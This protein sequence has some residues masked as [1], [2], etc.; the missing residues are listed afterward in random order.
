MEDEALGAAGLREDKARMTWLE[1]VDRRPG[2]RVPGEGLREGIP[3]CQLELLGSGRK[4]LDLGPG[5]R[6][7]GVAG[8][9]L[10]SLLMPPARTLALVHTL[11]VQEPTAFR[12][13]QG[14]THE[15]TSWGMGDARI[16]N[17]AL[18]SSEASLSVTQ[19]PHVG[20]SQAHGKPHL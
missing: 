10:L 14:F 12:H 19:T 16:N 6:R 15:F 18:P 5:V 1:G 9:H 4:G 8:P 7:Q 11:L 13:Q 2:C 17:P 3:T 20:L